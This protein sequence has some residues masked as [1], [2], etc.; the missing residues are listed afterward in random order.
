MG[1]AGSFSARGRLDGDMPAPAVFRRVPSPP[2]AVLSRRRVLMQ[3]A[4]DLIEA[5][6]TD[7]RI[8]PIVWMQVPMVDSGRPSDFAPDDFIP[9]PR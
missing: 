3:L 4:L 5:V 7:L 9:M 1:I 8:D 6:K 2:T